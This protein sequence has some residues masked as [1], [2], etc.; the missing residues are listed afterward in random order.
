MR[1]QL[2]FLFCFVCSVSALRTPRPCRLEKAEYG[3][4]CSCDE[5]YCDSLNVPEPNYGNRYILVTS[6]E[7]GD[8]F[9]YSNGRFLLD[10]CEKCDSYS[11]TTIKINKYKTFQKI[12]GFGGAFTGAV[13]YILD[14]FPLNVRNCVYKSYF[15]KHFGMGYNLLRIPIGGSDFDLGP[16]AY[17]EYPENDVFLSNFTKLDRRD[18]RRNEQ[19][20]DVMDITSNRK[21]KI[22]SVVW[23]PPVWM[24]TIHRWPGY[25]YNE[26]KP[27]YYQTYAD[28]YLKYINLM[29]KDGMPI[30]GVSTG[31]EPWYPTVHDLFMMTYWSAD[32]QTKWLVENLAPTLRHTGVGIHAIDGFRSEV[33]PFLEEMNNA[34]QYA[35]HTISYFNVHAYF[36]K[37]TSP[38]ILDNLYKNYPRI[39]IL[40]TEMSFA[41]VDEPK[42]LPGS[43]PRAVELIDILFEHMQHYV[44]GYIDWNLML[45]STGGPRWGHIGLDAYILANDNFTA[46]IK[47]PMF[48]AQAHFTKFIPPGSQ[49]IEATICGKQY[50]SLQT[51]AF[52]RPDK[53]ITVILHNNSPTDII[54]VKVVDKLK[55]QVELYLKPRSINTLIY[56]TRNCYWSSNIRT[57]RE[58]S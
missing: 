53:K 49:R 4:I 33:E 39:P 29:R 48:Y 46:I 2:F 22:L 32:K 9:S 10:S 56:S 54:T 52:K 21:L 25:N 34:S 26:I 1:I 38:I 57:N 44:S 20:K 7:A 42:I 30:W 15:S 58:K 45:N 13:S 8:R 3:Y 51:V 23:S 43:W 47:Q 31:N 16:W 11:E 55:G 19:I 12:V 50:P 18:V 24:K 41:V 27:E 6:S 28:Y 37:Q 36:D 17:N 40:Y 35:L 14:R 5:N